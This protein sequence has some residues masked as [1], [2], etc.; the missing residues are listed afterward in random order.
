MKVKTWMILA[1]LALVAIFYPETQGIGAPVADT[2]QLITAPNATTCT[3]CEDCNT[4]LASGNYDI[5]TLTNDITN[6]GGAC[7]SLILGE[8]DVTFDCD[9]HT[10]D[11]DDIAIDPESGIAMLHGDNNT[12]QNC[13]VSDF[14]RGIY[15]ADVTNHT[16]SNN[17]LT[18]NGV[19]IELSYATGSTLENNVA[20]DNYTGIH[21]SNSSSNAI[22]TNIVC[23]NSVTDLKIETTSTGN[24]GD[25]NTCDV[26][27]GWNDAG[28][29]GCTYMCSGTTTC[30]NCGDCTNKLNGLFTKVML[31]ADIANATDTCITFGANN[32]EFDCNGHTIDGNDSGTDAGVYIAN[33]SGNTVKNCTITDFYDGV[34]LYNAANNTLTRNT[35]RSNRATGMR[36]TTSSNSN[37]ISWNTISENNTSS[38]WGLYLYNSSSNDIYANTMQCNDYGIKFDNVDNNNISLNTV[39][40]THGTDFDLL[41]SSTGNS[42]ISNHCDA[43][44]AW[45]DTGH[46][47]C[48]APCNSDRCA[49]CSDNIQNGDET[50]VDCGGTYCPE[51]AACTG[52]PTTQYAPGDTNCNNAWPTNEGPELDINT[53][54]DSCELIE[55]CNPDLDYIVEDALTCCEYTDYNTRL[56]GARSSGKIAACDYAHTQAY[57][58]NFSSYF[59]TTTLKQC[60]AYYTIQSFGANAVYMQGYFHGEWC[61]YDSDKICPSGCSRFHVDPTAWEMGTSASCAGSGGE[62]PDFQMGGHRCEYIDA[63]IFGDY[64]KHGYWHSDTNWQSN[65]DSVVDVPAHASINR[66]STGTCVDYA[67]AVATALRKMGYSKDDVLGVDGDGHNYNL[68]RFPGDTKWYYVD[69]TGNTA[70]GVQMSPS[71][72][73]NYCGKLDDGCY[74]DVYSESRGHCPSNSMIHGC[75]STVRTPQSTEMDYEPLQKLSNTASCTR[76]PNAVTGPECTE[77]NPCPI[78][79][80]VESEDPG[81]LQEIAVRKLFNRSQ[82]TLG[83]AVS[84]TLEIENGE[85]TP[86]DVAVR[87]YFRPDFTYNLEA[88][89]GAYENLTFQYHD[90]VLNIPAGTTEILNFTATP[91]SLGDYAF[92]ATSVS[93]EGNTYKS[94]TPIVSVVCAANGT[95]D[96]GE[97]T[98]TCTKDCA[99]GSQ[100]G[101]CDMVSDDKNDPDCEYGLDPDF[102]PT[103]DTDGDSV[104]DGQDAC[105]LTSK[106]DI[107]SGY[108]NTEG[109][110]CSQMLCADEDPATVDRCDITAAACQHL[111]DDD[112][113]EKPNAEDNC[114]DVYN[115]DQR[116]TDTD[117]TGDMCEIAPVSADITL[118][119]GT[120][121]IS[122]P[123]GEAAVKVTTSDITLD[124]NGATLNGTGTGYGIYV[125]D[126]LS[127]ITI[128]NCTVT[129]YRYG[130]Y[131]NGASNIVLTGNT[132]R[133]NQYGI[134]LGATDTNTVTHNTASTN[135][136]AGIYVEGTT[137]NTIAD[138]TFNSNGNLGIFLHTSPNNIISNNQICHN[139]S[140]DIN[141]YDSTSV[142]DDNTCD[143]PGEWNDTGET[144]CSTSCTGY[145]LYLPLIL[146]N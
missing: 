45:N 135:Q 1:L 91:K 23:N 77:L 99:S 125:P 83:E 33:Q 142:G 41:S 70:G 85:G 78:T 137:G 65:S 35:L 76:T 46:T 79:S 12:I 61:C 75:E 42:G 38:A 66:L 15:I 104:T 25:N 36:L 146:K 140:A 131:I 89:T 108:V 40:S 44:G 133:A 122:V 107:E 103:E 29:T 19:G 124:C 13:T 56:T 134:V 82:I 136:E 94:S 73:Y 97:S 110:A 90:W 116:D 20:N 118:D 31:N 93:S 84:V 126:S 115:P 67:I 117:G 58:N 39:C 113:D 128:Q 28:T 51:C 50:D 95:C 55:V 132:L 106:E 34:S 72:G 27:D 109:C 57:H 123:E 53:E 30:N 71:T 59:N 120:Y 105:P 9:G 101:V 5:V 92:F 141:V 127:N 49:T 10:I 88:L 81:P 121:T 48:T 139:T 3:S 18:S 145:N 6:Y 98:F 32:I 17:T 100:D 62:T 144:G 130:I 26:P 64:G 87:E 69:T 119:P 21:L 80:T 129:N 24:G 2:P 37:T 111:P 63:W 86:I 11:G 52:E 54:S 14:S 138:N 112:Q 74:N 4:K 143:V 7:I 47:G 16:L 96:A 8:S 22:N 43:P 60:M 68:V 102:N 114:P